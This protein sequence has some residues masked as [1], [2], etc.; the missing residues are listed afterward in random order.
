MLLQGRALTDNWVQAQVRAVRYKD[1]ESG[2]IIAFSLFIF[3]AMI[4]FGGIAVDLMMYEN[5]RTSIQNSTDRAVL[6]AANLNQTVDPK[7]V[8]VDYLAKVGV[9]IDEDDVEVV[10]IG[11]A[12]V[13]T[14][15][16]VS[17]NVAAQY[18]TLLMH[19]VGVDTLPY[20]AISEAEEAI[21]D[22]EVSLVLDVS[23]SMGDNDKLPRLKTAAKDFVS[24]VLAGAE[25]NRVSLSLVPYSTQVSVGEALLE[26]FTTTQSHDHSF[27]SNFQN[28]NMFDSTAISQ[29]LQQ[30]GAFDPWRSWRYGTGLRYPVCRTEAYMDILPWSNNIDTINDQIDDFVDGGNTSIDVAFKWG[31][32]LLDPSMNDV[33]VALEDDT[34]NGVEIDPEFLVRPHAYSFE[35]GLKFIVVMTDG[36]NTDQYYLKNSFKT[37]SAH[38]PGQP[39]ARYYLSG[40]SVWM[41]SEEPGDRD[42]DGVWNEGWYNLTERKWANLLDDD[43][44]T[45]ND[46][47]NNTIVVM[48]QLSWLDFWS[49][50]TVARYAYAEYHQTSPWDADAYW[51]NRNEPYTYVPAADKDDRLAD[52]CTAAKDK[53]VVVFTIGFEVTDH[54]AGVMRTCASTPQ[55]FY[56]VEGLDIEYA[57]ASI[58]NQINQLKLTQ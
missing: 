18:D 5:R 26:E 42:D 54:S 51:D 48:E 45:G 11:T 20:S 40:G 52:I 46:Y 53:G 7:L 8:V 30:T 32:A 16:Q 13:I 43:D 41:K 56:R 28:D 49:R 47:E 58:K 37:G 24:G 55:H 21:N 57:F 33:L 15:R 25:D 44:H 31:A 39:T 29:T 12:P 14:G 1:D 22:I 2:S 4:M 3:L 38:R 27:C 6:A 10:E 35:D 36:I 34:T 9:E 17:V 19:M 23:G 50:V